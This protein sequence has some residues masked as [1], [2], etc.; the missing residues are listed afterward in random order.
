[1][2]VFMGTI[3]AF[4]FYFAPRGWQTCSGQLIS[5]SQNSALFSLLGTNFGGDGTVTFGL[6][7]L[8]SRVAVGQ[9]QGPGLSNYVI[10]EA[11]GSEQ[12][13]LTSQNL[14]AHTHMLMAST[15]AA[16]DTT[17]ASGDVLGAP[18]GEDAD[19]APVTVKMYAPAG[20]GMVPLSPTSI[21]VAGGSIPMSVIQPLLCINYSIAMEG[22]F[23]SRS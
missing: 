15:V 19:L 9:G 10:G 21:G 3:Q 7:D 11:T 17:P 6:P 2:D 14:P 13:G 1:M 20:T 23:P 4:G 22:I 5:I 8:R 16:T 18:N 12:V